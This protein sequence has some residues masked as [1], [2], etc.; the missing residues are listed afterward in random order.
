M[1]AKELVAVGG[2]ARGGGSECGLDFDS[3][4]TVFETLDSATCVVDFKDAVN[5]EDRMVL[6]L[7]AGF[8]YYLYYVSS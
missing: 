5:C 8:E 4:T 7:P 6:V 2:A 3:F 1:E